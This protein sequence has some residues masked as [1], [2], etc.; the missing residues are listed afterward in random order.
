MSPDD[1]D[2]DSL[3]TRAATQAVRGAALPVGTLVATVLSG[4]SKGTTRAVGARLTI[5][6]AP[7]NDL[8][9]SDD[10][11]SRLH[12]EL[13]RTGQAIHVKD[14]GSTNGTRIDG[15]RIQDAQLGPGSV[16]RVGEI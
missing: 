3:K 11:V 1:S 7:G 13:T 15:T 12:C 4:S 9:L 8:V 16:L 5:G 2:D 6:K 14:L 10:T